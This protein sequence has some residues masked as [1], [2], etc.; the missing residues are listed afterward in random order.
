MVRSQT[1]IREVANP[2]SHHGAAVAGWYRSDSFVPEQQLHGR[3]VDASTNQDS[4]AIVDV[5]GRGNLS[6]G[7]RGRLLKWILLKQTMNAWHASLLLLNLDQ[8]YCNRV[9]IRR[10]IRYLPR[11]GSE[12]SSPPC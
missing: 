3:P 5:L 2:D 9:S 11:T 12:L 10:P 7:T 6:S 8:R 4:M 1:R